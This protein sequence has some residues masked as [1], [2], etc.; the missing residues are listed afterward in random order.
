MGPIGARCRPLCLVL[1]LKSF[2]SVRLALRK[3]NWMWKR[4]TRTLEYKLK[5]VCL[6]PPLILERW[7]TGGK[8][9]ALHHKLPT[10][11]PKNQ[12]NWRR[13]FRWELEELLALI[14]SQTTTVLRLHISLHTVKGN[15]CCFTFIIQTSYRFLLWP[16]LFWNYTGRGILGNVF[17]LGLLCCFLEVSFCLVSLYI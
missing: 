1:I 11:W 17:Q 3:K 7:I 5:H 16:T 2:W 6:L 9:G 15:G 8:E 13:G 12:R 10:C 4:I 14:H